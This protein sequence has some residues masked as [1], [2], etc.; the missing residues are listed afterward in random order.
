MSIPTTFTIQH[1]CGH[2]EDRD[3][4]NV[5]AGQRAGKAE[6][7]SS[8]PCFECFKRTSDR[9]VSKERQAER[10]A[11]KQEAAEDQQRSNLPI[12]QGSE[13]QVSWGME[14]RFKLLRDAYTDLVQEGDMSEEEFEEQVLEAARKIGPAKWWIDNRESTSS[15]MI[16]LLADPGLRP[17]EYATENTY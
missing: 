9:K 1:K 3:L 13:K 11:L 6:W 10:D 7:W 17:D 15:M 8:K 16:D 5:P 4:S 14:E 2:E 12:L